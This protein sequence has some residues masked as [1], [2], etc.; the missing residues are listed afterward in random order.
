MRVFPLSILLYKTSMLHSG[1]KTPLCLTM[2]WICSDRE[3]HIL[4]IVIAAYYVSILRHNM[5]CR[6]SFM[7]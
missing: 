3:M 6:L 2:C 7:R 4:V 1:E 5:K